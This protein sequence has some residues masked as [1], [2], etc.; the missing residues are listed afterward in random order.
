MKELRLILGD[1]LNSQ[2][3]WFQQHEPHIDYVLMEVRSETDYCQHHIQ[4]VVGI[5]LAMRDFAQV[6]SD[7]GHNVIYISLDDP[8]NQQS[9]CANLAKLLANKTYHTW[10]WQQPDEYRLAQALQGFANN[11]ITP[12][13]CVS[14][15]HFL[16]DQSVVAK[17]FKPGTQHFLME[18]FYRH[19]R[20]REHVLMAANG[21][22][23]SGK[24][25]HDAANRA[26]YDGAVPIPEPLSFANKCQHIVD[27]LQR[28]HVKTIGEVSGT[29]DWPIN[30]TQA[31]Q[32]LN[33]FISHQ[34]VHFGR[35]QDALVDGQGT[36]FH[37]RLS[38]ALNLKLL[39]P[40]EVIQAAEHAWLQGQVDIAACEGF[41]RQILGWREYMRCLYWHLYPGMSES[42]H[43]AHHNALP[44]WFWTG[45]TQMRCLS[46]AIKQ[47]LAT[48][49]AHHIQRL[50][51]TG[52]FALLA[53]VSP[54]AVN[55]W[56]LGI[57]VDA[58]EWVQWPNTHGM[59]QYAEGGR[60]ATKPY[61]ASGAYIH[62]QGDHCRHCHYDVKAKSG[63]NSCPL[64]S[65][66]WHFIDRHFDLLRPNHRMAI[67]LKN[68]QQRK[69]EDKQVV[70][71]QAEQY[72]RNINQL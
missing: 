49:Y 54:S 25:N 45:D 38:F 66:Y 40:R 12:S 34:L 26:A 65:F 13:Y 20:K 10:S 62:R 3:S 33:D 16:A 41:I 1:Q 69:P 36:L 30:R 47:S 43:F 7:A 32:L 50:M 59:S 72:L 35:Y 71:K 51:V 11:E 48:G 42:N 39:S 44:S 4:K 22:P 55:E 52:N 61:V 56:Y 64:N 18:T 58:F 31:L 67:V 37:S 2:H 53:G 60:I 8:G 27:M 17:L 15:E 46:Q 23:V 29:L 5:F 9:I 68:W 14:T 24:W 19:M 28:C 21:K 57:Y 63:N 70:I 6:L